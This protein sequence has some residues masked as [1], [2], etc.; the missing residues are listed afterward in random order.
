MK[1][2][3]HRQGSLSRPK[4]EWFCRYCDCDEFKRPDELLN[5]GQF[6]LVVHVWLKSKWARLNTDDR[7]WLAKELYRRRFQC[8]EPELGIFIDCV[9]LA[10][11]RGIIDDA[12]ELVHFI[13]VSNE[14]I[15][16]TRSLSVVEGYLKL[17]GCVGDISCSIAWIERLVSGTAAAIPD[18]FDD[19]CFIKC[20]DDTTSLALTVHVIRKLVLHG[21]PF[22]LP[23]EQFY[24]AF[25]D[26]EGEFVKA[27]HRMLRQDRERFIQ[28]YAALTRLPEVAD[29]FVS[30]SSAHV[31]FF[32]ALSME[33]QRFPRQV[34]QFHT[35]LRLKCEMESESHPLLALLLRL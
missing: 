35:L 25:V 27:L 31:D 24:R 5:F 18:Y 22:R 21:N 14:R 12:D 3:C 33:R 20:D 10:L 26:S 32:R 19:Y 16:H 6:C 15:K 13:I 29:V 4:M 28:F 9:R 1:N 30:D 34:R 2:K 23:P 8:T 7:H 17:L 11:K